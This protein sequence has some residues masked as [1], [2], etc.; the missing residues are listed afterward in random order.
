MYLLTFFMFRRLLPYVLLMFFCMAVHAQSHCVIVDKETGTPIRNV[1]IHADNGKTT[2]T[3]Y[4]GNAQIEGAFKS[5]TIS[6]A[7]YLTR[8]VDY[9]ELR[10]T[11]WRLP[12]ENRLSEV[13][14]YGTKQKQI[15]ALV[16]SAIADVA[17]YAPP[18]TGVSFDFCELI[19]KKPLS[20]KARKKNKELL[21][22]WDKVYVGEGNN[23]NN[24]ING[25]NEGTGNN[26]N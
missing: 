17:S 4:R 1:N 10:D 5:A 14:V 13:V 16:K 24:G 2:V 7:S 18:Q 11:L 3:D 25:A 19:R 26:G 12:R 6:H 22:Q 20:K 8:I 23:G 15:S 9:S 21:E